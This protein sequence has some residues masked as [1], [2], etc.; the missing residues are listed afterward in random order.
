MVPAV[1]PDDVIHGAQ[2]RSPILPLLSLGFRVLS[3]STF[4]GLLV[5]TGLQP[6]HTSMA[7]GLGPEWLFSIYAGM[8][9]I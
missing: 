8:N 4:L 7:L 6:D 5:C 1:G 3:L 9:L 2:M